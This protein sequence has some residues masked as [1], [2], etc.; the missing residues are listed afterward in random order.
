MSLEQDFTDLAA[1]PE[2]WDSYGA[3]K[4][5][6]AAISRAREIAALYPDIGKPDVSPTPNGGVTLE[7]ESGARELY[8]TI[9]EDGPVSMAMFDDD[10]EQEWEGLGPPNSTFRPKTKISPGLISVC[11][12]Y[13]EKPG[14]YCRQ[15]TICQCWEASQPSL[16]RCNLRPIC[17]QLVAT[18][19]LSDG[20]AVETG[21]KLASG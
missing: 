6:K 18:P 12:Q 7:W 8:I 10:T 3:A 4:V 9:S 19:R 21:A 11:G 1:L 20:L 14:S 2:N 15:R 5:S 17:R 16:W 13:R